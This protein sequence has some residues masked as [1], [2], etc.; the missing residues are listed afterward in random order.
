MYTLKMYNYYAKTY[1]KKYLNFLFENQKLKNF[2]L[3]LCL[4]FKNGY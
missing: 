2:K 4:L 3:A 1:S